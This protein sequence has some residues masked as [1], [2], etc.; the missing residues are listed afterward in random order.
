MSAS[1]RESAPSEVLVDAEAT[2]RLGERL[3]RAVPPGGI[4]GLVGPLGAG[5]TTL[6]RGALHALGVREAVVSPTFLGLRR[7]STQDAGIVYHIDL[8]RSDDA[9]WLLGEGVE[10]DLDDGARAVVEW[11]DLDPALAAEAWMIVELG[12]V[13]LDDGRTGRGA[14]MRRNQ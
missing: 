14:W 2:E 13:E 12:V 8:Y 6:A 7:Y 11:I 5:K 9:T 1:A 4:L 10:E 3:G